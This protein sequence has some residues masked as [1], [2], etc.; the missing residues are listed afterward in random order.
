MNIYEYD[1]SLATHKIFITIK[2]LKNNL[3]KFLIT[4][5][6]FNYKTAG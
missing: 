3:T 2:I 1:R 5:Y 6:Y 4:L